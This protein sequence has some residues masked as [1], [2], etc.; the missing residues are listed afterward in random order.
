MTASI[1]ETVWTDKMVVTDNSV[2][3]DKDFDTYDTTRIVTNRKTDY[4]LDNI[5]FI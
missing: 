1:V 3:T 2:E 4:T 5:A